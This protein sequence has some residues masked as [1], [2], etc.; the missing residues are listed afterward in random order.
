[1]PSS[2]TRLALT[3]GIVVVVLSLGVPLVAGITLH[4][5]GLA[6]AA[7]GSVLLVCCSALAFHSSEKTRMSFLTGLRG[8]S[9]GDSSKHSPTPRGVHAPTF[10]PLGMYRTAMRTGRTGAAAPAVEAKARGVSDSKNGKLIAAPRP[11]RTVRR[12]MVVGLLIGS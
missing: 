4:P 5:L 11:R 9:V 3:A 7:L 12:E 1:M 8:E 2:R 6:Q 10:T